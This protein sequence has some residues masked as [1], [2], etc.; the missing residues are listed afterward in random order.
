M[1]KLPDINRFAVWAE[2]MAD[3]SR[4]QVEIPLSKEELRALVNYYD[5]QLEIAEASIVNGLPAG[6]GKD[7]LL[8]HPEIARELL[9]RVE[10][11]RKEVL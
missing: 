6:D 9:I 2:A 5:N 1:A 4:M 11:E 8:A 10:Q 3:L 7:W